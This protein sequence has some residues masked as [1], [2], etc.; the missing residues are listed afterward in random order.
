MKK[1][2]ALNISKT[3]LILTS[4]LW[5][6]WDESFIGYWAFFAFCFCVI[7]LIFEVVEVIWF[8]NKD[9]D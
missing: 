4:L 6:D 9:N 8:K 5:L 3:V 2:Q 1:N 7:V